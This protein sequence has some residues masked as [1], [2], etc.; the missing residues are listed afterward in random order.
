MVCRFV[1]LCAVVAAGGCERS[2]A[3]KGT[4]RNDSPPM[5]GHAP[6]TP[7]SDFA[8][9]LPCPQ[10][11]PPAPPPLP[12]AKPAPEPVVP[13]SATVPQPAP[14][15]NRKKFDHFQEWA[16]KDLPPT[17]AVTVKP[18]DPPP[19]AKPPVPS[20]A[21]A[22]V[23]TPPDPV[24]DVA[25][26]RAILDGFAKQYAALTDFEARLTKREVVNGKALPQDEILYRWRKQPLSV[27]MKV[28]SENGH[29]REVLYVKGQ[30][31]NKIHVVTGKGD[32]ALVG[33]GYKTTV[34][35]DSRQAVAK[36]R[37]R[38]YEAGFGRTLAGLTK[39]V[40]AMEQNR[41]GVRVKSLGEVKR[42]EYVQ[43]LLCVEGTLHPG[44]EP[45]LP[46]GGTRKV[47]FDP[48]PDSPSFMLPV[49]VVTT[50]PDGREV[51]YYC[52]DRIK[53][54]SGLT[55]ADWTPD[56]LTGKRK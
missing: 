36:S 43:P 45:Q 22:P 29:G 14:E 1:I 25:A 31:D 53:S 21:P 49:L 47:F 41:P 6:L 33:V 26:V 18:S 11:V 44:D 55:D 15:P 3:W 24:N 28:L 56:R 37:Y 10:P 34:D 54:P 20:P 52:F 30:F 8:T 12:G 48:K 23:A 9:N 51:E 7:P 5:M 35:P 17:K 19:P 46:K 42:P 27:S 50:E 39:S 2:R 32:N 13:V 40:E 38:I 16:G 4:V